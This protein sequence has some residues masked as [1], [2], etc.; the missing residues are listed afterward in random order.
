[1][2]VPVDSAIASKLRRL[3]FMS[4]YISCWSFPN[5]H[6]QLRIS[7]AAAVNAQQLMVPRYCQVTT[8]RMSP[9]VHPSPLTEQMWSPQ[10]H[11]LDKTHVGQKD[12]G[13]RLGGLYRQRLILSQ[14]PI[15][16]RFW[17]GLSDTC[18]HVNMYK[19]SSLDTCR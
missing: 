19:L 8:L 17:G 11:C 6:K 18:E 3:E 12:T 13:A 14:S 5:K 7:S 15:P 2:K 4:C 1:M 9:I 10:I 16:E